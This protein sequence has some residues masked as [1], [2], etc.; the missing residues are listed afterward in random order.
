MAVGSSV[1]QKRG[2]SSNTK[3][4]K[5]LHNSTTKSSFFTMRKFDLII[6]GASGF[7]GRYVVERLV[8]Q[9][10]LQKSSSNHQPTMWAIAVRSP[11]KMRAY[12]REMEA[13]TGVADLEAK[14]PVLAADVTDLASMRRAFSQ[15]QLVMSCIGPYSLLGEPVLRAAIDA[16][17]HYLDLSGEPL[18]MERVALQYDQAARDNEV[19]AVSSCG[20]DSIPSDV[21]TQYLKEQFS[22][23]GGGH[24]GTVEHYLE[25]AFH[26]ANR[27]SFASW[28]SLIEGFKHADQL[29]EVRR[30]LFSQF[31]PLYRP[32]HY[33]MVQSKLIRKRIFLLCS[34]IFFFFLQSGTA[35][36][37]TLIEATLPLS[38]AAT[39]LW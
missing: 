11:A 8:Q 18:F 15:G 30:R 22:A 35:S 37:L 33:P 21:G 12:L 28:V 16:R 1:A 13:R 10:L 19:F 31:G 34:H 2:S 25:T 39:A 23:R 29:R 26:P 7:T 5:V 27:Y 17:A 3:N 4:L 6:F 14:V 24:L 32:Y 38:P 20:F 9:T 36:V